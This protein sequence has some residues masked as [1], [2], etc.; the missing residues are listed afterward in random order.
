MRGSTKSSI[1]SF[2][3]FEWFKR[4]HALEICRYRSIGRFSP[5]S[6]R[7]GFHPDVSSSV[8]TKTFSSGANICQSAAYQRGDNAVQPSQACSI[9]FWNGQQISPEPQSAWCACA[10]DK[11]WPTWPV[12]HCRFISSL[13]HI[14]SSS[15]SRALALL[16]GH[17]LRCGKDTKETWK[18]LVSFQHV[19][20]VVCNRACARQRTPC[21]D[22]W[23]GYENDDNVIQGTITLWNRWQCYETEDYKSWNRWQCSSQHDIH[24]LI[25]SQPPTPF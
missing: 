16:L 11:T 13:V 4:F 8:S 25:P 19:P 14:D 1:H 18:A 24:I 17:L 20:R 5:R 10:V 12:D 6:S 22:R 15:V 23:Q 7:S 9:R 3:S 2:F 21:C